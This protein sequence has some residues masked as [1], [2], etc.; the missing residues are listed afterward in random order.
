MATS[1]DSKILP[2]LALLWQELT[3]K[4]VFLDTEEEKLK[5]GFIYLR[6]QRVGYLIVDRSQEVDSDKEGSTTTAC[7][8]T[9]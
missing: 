7:D 5:Q 6:F 2:K 8:N 9:G 1:P 3:A 4:K